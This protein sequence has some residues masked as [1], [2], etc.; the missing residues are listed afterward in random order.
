MRWQV[1]LHD[2]HSRSYVSKRLSE[3]GFRVFLWKN[4]N[5]V[6][7]EVENEARLTLFL[8]KNQINGKV[9]KSPFPDPYGTPLAYEI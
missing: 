3:S 1:Y 5:R 6:T 4:S 9:I 2:K 7:F 8:I